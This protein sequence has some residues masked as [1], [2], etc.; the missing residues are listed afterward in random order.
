[1]RSRLI[2][3][4]R[5]LLGLGLVVAIVWWLLPSPQ[6]RK[7]LLERLQPDLLYLLLGFLSTFVASIVTSARRSHC[8]LSW[9]HLRRTRA[10]A[11]L[12]T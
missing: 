11:A 4:L 7:D 12:R 2:A 10:A 6:E 8:P 3:I 1:M 5:F 9:L